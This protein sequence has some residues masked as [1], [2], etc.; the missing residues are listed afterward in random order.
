MLLC[1]LLTIGAYAQDDWQPGTYHDVN[2]ATATGLIRPLKHG[3][4]KNEASIEFKANKNAEPLIFT[5]SGLQ[6]IVMGRDSFVVA[7]APETSDWDNELD[8]V[9]VVFDDDADDMKLYMFQGS[10]PSNGGGARSGFSIGLGAGFGSYGRNVGI[11]A[12]GGVE[13]PIGG[14]SRGNHRGGMA[15]YYYG[16]NTAHMK[17]LTDVN[18]VDIMSQMLGDEPEIVTQ[19]HDNKYSLKNIDKLMRN[20]DKLRNAEQAKK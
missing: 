14:S 9:C 12:G 1:C 15:T 7:A 18:F 2:G 17:P 8:F 20:Y 4:I 13:I 6:S 10:A 19:L 16:S 5:A 3:P 11:G